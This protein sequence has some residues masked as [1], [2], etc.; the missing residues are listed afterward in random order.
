MELLAEGG[1]AG[2]IVNTV[3]RAQALARSLSEA[4]G[5]CTVVLVHSRFVAPDRAA[6]EVKLR[7]QLGPN[8]QS[9]PKKLIVV[10]TQVLEQSLDIDFDVLITDICPMDLLIQRIGRLHRH[11]G[12]ARPPRLKEPRCYVTGIKSAVCFDDGSEF[13]YGAYLLMGTQALLP[14][15]MT[16]PDDIS[17][18][19]QAAYAPDGVSV[20]QDI[21]TEYREA[22]EK[23][24]KRAKEAEHK[25]KAFQIGSPAGGSYGLSATIVDWLNTDVSKD[26]NDKRAEA[27]VRDTADS[28]QVLIIQKKRD[29]QFYSL[30]WIMDFGGK[31]LSADLARN[32]RLAQAVANCVV[33]LPTSMCA[34]WLIDS[35]I[36]ALETDCLQQLPEAWQQSEWLRGE[37]FLI[38]D[39]DMRARVLDF[40][41]VYDQGYGLCV[42]KD[43]GV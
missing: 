31:R 21:Q 41:L 43:G 1:C 33:S 25:A 18:L 36:A 28:V 9:R 8:S 4:F 16:L 17:P 26:P 32:H 39:E 14:E 19:V 29:E 30:P 2:L 11:G 7:E 38:L 42:R 40:D 12:R 3:A 27:T 22:K 5:D 23:H 15:Q 6:K 34:S 10:G 13:I 35:V 20:T 37:L 24:E